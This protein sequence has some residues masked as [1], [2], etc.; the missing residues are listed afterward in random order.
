MRYY[1]IQNADTGVWKKVELDTGVVVGTSREPWPDVGRLTS[2]DQREAIAKVRRP[3][4]P[5][6]TTDPLAGFR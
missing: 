2:D 1:Q 3:R 5:V 4:R 6:V